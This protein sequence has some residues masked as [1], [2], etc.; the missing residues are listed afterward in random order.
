MIKKLISILLIISI[1]SPIYLFLGIVR[2]EKYIA[3]KQ[4]K[5]I[6]VS[7]IDRD[8]LVCLKFS[9][10][11]SSS[12]LRWK[13]SKEFEFNGEMYDVV[14]K[15]IRNDSVYY[16][17]WWDKKETK[18]NKKLDA[19]VKR[20]TERLPLN[21]H[22]KQTLNNY[23]SSFFNNFSSHYDFNDTQRKAESFTIYLCNYTS[24]SLK[25]DIP[26]PKSSLV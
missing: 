8:Q 13:H 23:L 18:L 17:C 10:L 6:L 25:P 3:K 12:Q 5:K 26:P 2:F 24:R 20:A 1:V 7:N 15:E 14:E 22:K 16:W 19:L 21:S 9:L 4:I 11:E